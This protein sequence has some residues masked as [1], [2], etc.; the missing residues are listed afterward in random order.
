LELASPEERDS[1]IKKKKETIQFFREM[2]ANI[3]E[4]IQ[5]ARYEEMLRASV[6]YSSADIIYRDD[7]REFTERGRLNSQGS[8]DGNRSLAGSWE[9]RSRLNSFG[10]AP[11]RVRTISTMD[12]MHFC[13]L[14]VYYHQLVNVLYW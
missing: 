14:F 7:S 6:E 2:E 4:K 13:I 8:N 9:G 3:R 10:S 1:M 11:R 12:G 5:R